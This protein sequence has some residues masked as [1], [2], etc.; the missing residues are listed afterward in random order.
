MIYAVGLPKVSVTMTIKSLKRLAPVLLWLFLILVLIIP[1]FIYTHTFG[2]HITND[3]QRWGEM[4]SAFS[5]IYTPILSILT[6]IVLVA[7]IRIQASQTVHEHNQAYVH[8]ARADVEYYL[9]QLGL[10][11]DKCVKDQVS[12]RQFL[13]DSF[14]YV[15]DLDT[16]R[17]K[18][19]HQLAVE[20]N[21]RFPSI[22]AIWSAFYP[23][24]EGLGSS[25]NYPY[26]HNFHAAKQKAIAVISFGVCAALDNYYWC[27]SEGRAIF[28]FQYSSL[29]SESEI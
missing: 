11:L 27:L 24:L 25:S 9:A 13:L 21:R 19:F 14:E 18:D 22:G 2:W 15:D 7:Q 3:H 28:H 29:L 26:E 20:I 1:I 4:G 16:L 8:E 12:V 5:G 6:L 23:L 17:S 10:E